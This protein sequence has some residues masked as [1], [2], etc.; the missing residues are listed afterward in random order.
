MY[1]RILIKLSGEILQ[2][3]T[4]TKNNQINLILEEIANLK[5][6][7][8]EIIIVLGAG[9]IWRYEDNKDK[10]IERT[11]SD[12][13]GMLGTIMNAAVFNSLLKKHQI[14]NKIY[15]PLHIP[16]L[17]NLYTQRKVIRA[18]EQNNII[19][20]AGGT[21]NPFFTTDSAAALRALE[22]NCDVII[23]ATKVDGV[24]D[25]DPLKNKNAKKYDQISFTEVIQKNI[26]V[27]DQTAFSLCKNGN[28]PIIVLNMTK[29]NAIINALQGKKEGT[30]VGNIK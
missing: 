13:I 11:T 14:K 26:K 24:Y 19:I 9:N 27:M 6:N 20:C 16:Q 23:K 5:K 21:G 2:N 18:I 1:K 8:Y 17:T 29:K 25:Q 22:L 30:F 10:N 28:I 12:Y 4:K 3:K 7:N 15:S